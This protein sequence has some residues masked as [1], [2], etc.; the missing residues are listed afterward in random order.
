MSL[1]VCFD[2]D[3]FSS[4]FLLKRENHEDVIDD[5]YVIQRHNNLN[6]LV[7]QLLVFYSVPIFF[8]PGHLVTLN[9][10]LLKFR[11]TSQSWYLGTTETWAIIGLYWKT[12]LSTLWIVYSGKKTILV[13]Q[14]DAMLL[15]NWYWILLNK[16]AFLIEIDK[17]PNNNK[18]KLNRVK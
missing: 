13:K 16:W 7:I 10:K 4:L 6:W 15:T 1:V 3:F 5:V 11:A 18:N 2:S 12:K 8:I 17:I 9:E 14:E